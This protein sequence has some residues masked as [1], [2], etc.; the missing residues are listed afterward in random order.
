MDSY[1]DYASWKT[2]KKTTRYLF[3]F[4]GTKKGVLFLND[5]IYTYAKFALCKLNNSLTRVPKLVHSQIVK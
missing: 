5:W 4:F 3:N 1:K 2:W